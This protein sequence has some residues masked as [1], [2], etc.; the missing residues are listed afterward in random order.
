MKRHHS[1]RLQLL[2]VSAGLA[3]V[4]M[5]ANRENHEERGGGGRATDRAS[6]GAPPG[7]QVSRERP[8]REQMLQ[9]GELV[10]EWSDSASSADRDSPGLP[11]VFVSSRPSPMRDEAFRKLLAGMKQDNAAVLHDLLDARHPGDPAALADGEWHA[12]LEKWGR[13]DGPAAVKHLDENRALPARFPGIL[14]GWSKVDPA[15]AAA[16]FESV[17]RENNSVPWLSTGCRELVLGWLHLDA[18]EAAAWLDADRERP[19]YQE[20]SARLAAAVFPLDRDKALARA[21][22]LAG[23]W[24]DWAYGEIERQWLLEAPDEARA[25]FANAGYGKELIDQIAAPEKS[26]IDLLQLPLGGAGDDSPWSTA[27]KWGIHVT[28]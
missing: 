21:G 2:L 19:G 23:P 8:Q 22:S 26:G 3:L 28:E 18:G 12:L 17:S 25:A 27:E 5:K 9:A 15:A 1:R 4:A 10:G 20:A 14:G 13:L 16:W 6:G 7:G 24:A 11:G